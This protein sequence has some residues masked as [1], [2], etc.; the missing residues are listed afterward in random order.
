MYKIRGRITKLE[1]LEINSNDKEYK[2]VLL[3]I[4]ESDTGFN[5]VQQFEIFGEAKLNVIEHS[6][7]L[8]E[9]QFVR[10][11][12]YIKSREY[13]GKWYNSLQVKECIIEERQEVN[14]FKDDEQQMP[15]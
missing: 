6:K 12:F 11:E 14:S 15:F 4:E 2:K 1:R 7:K 13:N 5:H 3:T 8:E 9:D 10:I